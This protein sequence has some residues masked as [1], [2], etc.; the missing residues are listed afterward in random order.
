MAVCVR[1]PLA[2][3]PPR[4]GGPRLASCPRPLRL[5]TRPGTYTAASAPP[6]AGG[7]RREAA[8]RAARGD[9]PPPAAAHAPP[10]SHPPPPLLRRAAAAAA[11]ALLSAALA[12]APLAPGG[13][14]RADAGA[15]APLYDGASVVASELREGLTADLAALER[16]AWCLSASWLLL[17][18][19]RLLRCPAGAW[20][21]GPPLPPGA[22]PRRP[23]CLP[24]SSHT[25]APAAPRPASPRPSIQTHHQRRRLEGACVHG[26]RRPRPEGP[27]RRDA[28]R[29]V[30]AARQPHAVARRRPLLAQHPKHGVHRWVGL[31]G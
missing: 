29:A 27:R 25:P 3:R 9:A 19:R 30:G 22:H 23:P 13:A 1:L 15:A 28:A 21:G 7:G 18:A 24:P 6:G 2:T 17:P 10:P 4:Q 14:A 26:L 31:G 5:V 16:C 8:A 12:L 20:S 11:G